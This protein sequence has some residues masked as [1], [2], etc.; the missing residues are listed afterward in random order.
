MIDRSVGLV[1]GVVLLL[2]AFASHADA[3]SRN[4][5][6]NR[7]RDF[8]IAFLLTNGED[9]GP[10]LALDIASETP[11]V[12]TLTYVR[13]GISVPITIA[14]PNIPVR[15]KLDTSLL[16]LP[17]PNSSP[18]SNYT[19]HL[20]FNDEVVVY[21]MNTQRFSSDNFLALP[22]EVL[23][24]E[25][26]VIS[27]PN[28]IDPNAA[29]AGV[30]ASDFP[31]QFAVLATVDNTQVTIQPTVRLKGRPDTSPFTITLN[32]GEIYFGQAN[33]RAG[34]DLTGTYIRSNQKV[35]V[36]GSH[37]RTNIPWSEAVGRN[38]LIE[39]LPPLNRWANRA[40]V[41]PFYDLPKTVH[42]KDIFRVLAANDN[43]Q[44]FF[45]STLQTTLKARQY[46]E[47]QIDGPKLITATGPIM[48]AQYHHSSV[49]KQYI[50]Q[51]NDSIG[52]PFMMLV[53]A[54]EQFD[55][56][57]WF[58]SYASPH[59]VY[60]YVNVVVPTERVNTLRLDGSPVNVPFTT[61]DKT[62][63]SYAQIPVQLGY[64]RM[65]ARAPFG[66][67]MYGYGTYDGYGAPGAM[68]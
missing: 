43:T 48:V 54:P 2:I 38:H 8:R 42:D 59:F 26:L 5:V 66:L 29:A 30:N 10:E 20:Q 36:Y 49:S 67:Y 33:G 58:E 50:S 51:P 68:V 35:V 13:S 41:T 9:G 37:Q 60:H 6:D 40:I 17:D 16:I 27:Y 34:I 64:H 52:D 53:T 28:T 46:A 65:S 63:Y 45:D 24:T 61:I 14:Q 19:V 56:V 62:S 15:I 11:T 25:H 4:R 44:I 1:L 57:Y 12:G 18:I 47:F 21:G 23:G 3:Q 7:G 31:S 32:A 39:Q 55:S 22:Q